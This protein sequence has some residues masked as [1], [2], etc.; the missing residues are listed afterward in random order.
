DTEALTSAP[1]QVLPSRPRRHRVRY[2]QIADDLLQRPSRPSRAK[3]GHPRPAFQANSAAIGL[4][5][6]RPR[7]AF[8]ATPTLCRPSCMIERAYIMLM[9]ADLQHGP[10]QVFNNDGAARQDGETQKER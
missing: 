4:N 9:D 3:S 10:A 1:G 8:S 5:S 7:S 2:T 6:C